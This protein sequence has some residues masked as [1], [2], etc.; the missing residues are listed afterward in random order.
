MSSSLPPELPGKLGT[1]SSLVSVAE[2][3]AAVMSDKSMM[4]Y[5]EVYA[6]DAQEII[7]IGVKLSTIAGMKAR[8]DKLRRKLSNLD[9]LMRARREF[10]CRNLVHSKIRETRRELGLLPVPKT[11]VPETGPTE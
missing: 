8:R 6:K 4:Q 3:E 7:D 11:H 5:R 10:V 1:K 2:L 9:R